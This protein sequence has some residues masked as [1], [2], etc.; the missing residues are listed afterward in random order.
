MLRRILGATC[1]LV[2]AIH[3]TS[4]PAS[5]CSCAIAATLQRS[6][7]Y[8]QPTPL[9]AASLSLPDVRNPATGPP[10]TGGHLEALEWCKPERVRPDGQEVHEGVQTGGGE[11]LRAGG[12]DRGPGHWRPRRSGG[13]AVPVAEGSPV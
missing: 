5:A 11:S 3:S 7:E 4:S 1:V 10:R 2:A 6:V 9:H 12:D 13:R 8:R